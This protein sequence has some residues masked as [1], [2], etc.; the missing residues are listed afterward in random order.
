[1]RTQHHIIAE[2]AA[3][4]PPRHAVDIEQ[5]RPLSE[6]AVAATFVQQA[7]LEPSNPAFTRRKAMEHRLS[8]PQRTLTAAYKVEA[9]VNHELAYTDHLTGLPNRRSYDKK[10]QSGVE[11]LAV[12]AVDNDGFKNINDQLGHDRGDEV[13]LDTA[14]LLRAAVRENDFIARTG[15]DE[16]EILLYPFHGD[17]HEAQE[18][19]DAVKER[20][21]QMTSEYLEEHPELRSTGFGI[22]VAGVVTEPGIPAHVTRKHADEALNAIKD[23]LY[24]GKERRKKQ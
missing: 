10:I 22:S 9:A 17:T 3:E 12:V 6:V 16:F 5:I 14:N 13:I 2:V 24:E 4:L 7:C 8:Q 23:K 1:M 19:V 11:L 15:G 20:I 21:A 18:R